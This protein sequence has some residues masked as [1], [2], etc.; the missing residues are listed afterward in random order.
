MLST[1]EMK[2]NSVNTDLN[3]NEKHCFNEREIYLKGYSI[4]PKKKSL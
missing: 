3:L 1:C 4:K 2:A